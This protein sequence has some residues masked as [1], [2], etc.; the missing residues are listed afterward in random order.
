MTALDKTKN[1]LRLDLPVGLL[2]KNKSNPNKMSARE[3]D[4]LVDNLEKT[5]FTDPILCRPNDY[6]SVK[7]LVD[8]MSDAASLIAELQASGLTFRIVG[9]HH[10]FDAAVYVGFETVP[11]TVIMDPEFDDEQEKFQLVRMNTIR[12]KLDPKAFFDLYNQLSDHYTEEILQ[13]AFGFAD[14]AEF[15]KL[16]DQTAK[17][18]PDPKLQKKFK[19]AAQEVKTIDGISKLL[20]EMF[21]RYGDTV[22]Y[23]YMVVDYGGQRSV[24]VRVDKKTMDALDIVG[25]MCIENQRTMDDIVGGIVQLIAKGELKETVDQLIKKT[26][27]VDLPENM[28]VLPTKDNVEK[29]ASL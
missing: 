28:S 22:P 21:T 6:D 13:D 7:A 3:F 11:C 12:G 25:E 23:G 9:G 2:E 18:L 8:G 27:P 17:A 16:V 1:L 20:N 24:W 10:R 15:R 4:L 26:P 14:E 5:G 19:E 29:V